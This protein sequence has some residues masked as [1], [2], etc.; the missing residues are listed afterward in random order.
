MKV[1][2][3]IIESFLGR[4]LGI[5]QVD[6][7]G[8]LGKVEHPVRAGLFRFALSENLAQTEIFGFLAGQNSNGDCLVLIAEMF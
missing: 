7:V 1:C 4:S 8:I 5:R 6:G 2:L 3:I